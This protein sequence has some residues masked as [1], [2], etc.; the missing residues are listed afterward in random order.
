[1]TVPATSVADSPAFTLSRCIAFDAG[2]R[3]MTHGSKC[4]NLHGHRYQVEAIC[5]TNQLQTS[6]EQ[7]D[8]VLDFAFLKE[9][10]IRLIADPCDHGFIAALADTELLEMFTPTGLSSHDWQDG[11]R[12]TVAR[13]GAAQTSQTRLSTKLYVVPFQPTAER[14][15]RHWYELLAPAI[16]ERTGGLVHLIAVQVHETPNCVARYCP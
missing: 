9:D 16:K 4:R 13:H 14:L 5:G 10:M 12:Q 6:G 1:M 2:H 3:I 15:A 11:L 7:E 8:M